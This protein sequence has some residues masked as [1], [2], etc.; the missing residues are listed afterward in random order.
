MKMIALAGVAALAL[1]PAA[2]AQDGGGY[3]GAGG[4]VVNVDT[5]GLGDVTI[6]GV[7]FLGGYDFSDYFGAEVEGI[8]GV[9]EDDILG[10]D[11]SL[12]YAISGF[13]VGRLPVGETGSNLF[14]RVGYGTAEV[15]GSAGGAS[16][17]ETADGF[18]FGVGGEWAFAGPNRLR[19]DA[20]LLEGG[21]T[22]I[23]GVSYVRR[24]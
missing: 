15:E 23:Y 9:T 19:F 11:I 17:S 7:S 8:I 6:A 5:E 22:S 20:T 16:V 4:V 1:T 21:D 12:N 10:V 18:A 13:L 3:L 24:F 2:L 14:A